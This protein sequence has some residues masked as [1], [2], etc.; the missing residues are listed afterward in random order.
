MNQNYEIGVLGEKL[1]SKYLQEIGYKIIDRNFICKQGE[2]DIIAQDKNEKVFI[3]VKTRTNL[4]YGYPIEAVT[5][6]KQK[7][8]EKAT[9]YYLYK[10]FIKNEYVRIDVIEVYLYKNKYKINHIKQII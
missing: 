6:V 2:I 8:I 5:Q 7:H 1:A 4:N 3:E 10:N 9:Q